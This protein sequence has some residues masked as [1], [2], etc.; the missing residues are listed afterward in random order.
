VTARNGSSLFYDTATA[1][2]IVQQTEKMLELGV[3]AKLTPE[4]ARPASLTA[5]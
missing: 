5:N 1:L 2:E 3:A 4:L